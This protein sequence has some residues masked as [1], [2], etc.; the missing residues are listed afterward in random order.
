VDRWD[1]LGFCGIGVGFGEK[2]VRLVG[3]FDDVGNN[4]LYIANKLSK[5][6]ILFATNESL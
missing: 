3:A 2:E 4:I 1:I 6:F 5:I